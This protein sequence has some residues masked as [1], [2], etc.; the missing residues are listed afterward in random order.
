MGL[1]AQIESRITLARSHVEGTNNLGTALFMVGVTP[2]NVPL[3][4]E[5]AR[6]HVDKMEVLE[7]PSRYCL[8][9]YRRQDQSI[10]RMGIVHDP[11]FHPEVDPPLEPNQSVRI[12]FRD[13]PGRELTQARIDHAILPG[14]TLEYRDPT[15]FSQF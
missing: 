5:Q 8:A 9:V 13:K 6:E 1:E 14:T 4:S 12:Y 11:D 2:E 15:P 7:L 3:N 10:A